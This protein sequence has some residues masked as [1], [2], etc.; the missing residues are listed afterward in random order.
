[1]QGSGRRHDGRRHAGVA[2]F[3]A[4]ELSDS[5]KT[6]ASLIEKRRRRDERAYEL[7][8]WQQSC[9]V[10]RDISSRVRSEE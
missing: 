8:F 6:P 4:F 9:Q 3:F 1:M 7:S 10:L 5:G 2:F